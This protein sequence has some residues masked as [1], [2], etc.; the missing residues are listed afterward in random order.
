M[1]YRTPI[2]RVVTILQG[3]G[4]NPLSSPLTLAGLDFKVSAALVGTGRASDLVIVEDTAET[5]PKE[6]QVRIES[7]A[8]AMDLLDSKRPIT[9]VLVGPRPPERELDAIS[10]VSRILPVGSSSSP[11][12][13]DLLQNWLAVLLPLSVPSGG[14]QLANPLAE[15]AIH[16]D[17]ENEVITELMASAPSGTS[18]V[19]EQLHKIIERCLGTEPDSEEE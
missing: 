7:I 3:A 12:Q 15:L 10:R 4:Y 16:V 6:I 9:A 2:D 11:D 8:R 18:G 13:S 5:K 17:A 19:A 14:H 1:T